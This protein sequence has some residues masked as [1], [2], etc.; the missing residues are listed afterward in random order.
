MNNKRQTEIKSFLIR[1]FGEQKG[2]VLFEKQEALFRALIEQ[3]NG[4]S[5]SQTKTLTQTILPVIAMYKAL[6]EHRPEKALNIV[7]KY[8][9]DIVGVAKNGSMK[10]MER[11]PGFFN[12]YEK[13]FLK[14][15]RTSDLW[16]ST[17]KRGEN[18]FD[19]IITKCL[20]HDSCVENGCPE[21][22]RLFCDVDDVTYGGLNKMKFSRTRSLGCGGDCCDFHFSKK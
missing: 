14:V 2:G 13:I 16:E 21:L 19:V 3:T 11:V 8:M 15:M 17:Q 22:C 9:I 20:W 1:E 4:K 6:A 5:E 12:L 7:R 10:R 18:H